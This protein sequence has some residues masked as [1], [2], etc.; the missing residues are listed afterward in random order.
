MNI[1]LLDVLTVILQEQTDVKV[2]ASSGW[3]GDCVS[4]M[5]QPSSQKAEFMDGSQERAIPFQVT[6]KHQDGQEG[7][8]LAQSLGQYL[9]KSNLPL[10]SKNG[11]YEYNKH[12]VNTAP[13]FIALDENRYNYY[14]VGVTIT[15]TVEKDVL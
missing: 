4:V 5:Q 12:E 14:G 11:S 13:F 2:T 8:R 7:E 1:D 6:V 9:N 10:L 3:E 15:I